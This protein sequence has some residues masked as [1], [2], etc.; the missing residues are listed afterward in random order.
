[1]PCV[2]CEST[3]SP[4]AMQQVADET[5]ASFATDARH[6]LYVDSLSEEGGVVSSYLELLRYDVRT[7]VDGLTGGAR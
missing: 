3:V 4:K 1:M 2:F 5:G 6:V 7:I